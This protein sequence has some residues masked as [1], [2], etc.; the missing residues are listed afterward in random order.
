MIGGISF[1]HNNNNIYAY[2]ILTA[3]DQTTSNVTGAVRKQ[4]NRI[5]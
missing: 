1:G 5:N 2:V 4:D 3:V